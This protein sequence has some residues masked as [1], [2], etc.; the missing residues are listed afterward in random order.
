MNIN[1]RF[2]IGSIIKLNMKRA[3][4]QLQQCFER[5]KKT[6]SFYSSDA[7]TYWYWQPNP[8]LE[9]YEN[10]LF[11][12]VRIET[13]VRP[14]TKGKLEVTYTLA[15]VDTSKEIDVLKLYNLASKYK[16]SNDVNNGMYFKIVEDL[17]DEVEYNK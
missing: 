8:K 11:V 7:N 3:H 17:F 10:K 15:E 12:V 14:I 5:A 13:D 16:I 1:T 2:S 4:E 9:H 6:H